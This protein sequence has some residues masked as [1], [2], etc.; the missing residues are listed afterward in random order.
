MQSWIK[1][2]R[3]PG[4][5]IHAFAE[6]CILP[7][8]FLNNSPDIHF[9]IRG[10]YTRSVDLLFILTEL[11][12][13]TWVSAEV[14]SYGTAFLLQS[15]DSPHVGFLKRYFYLKLQCL[16]LDG[17][18]NEIWYTQIYNWM[19]VYCYCGYLRIR[20]MNIDL[21]PHTLKKCFSTNFEV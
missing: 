3:D 10:Y 16:G 5:L 11:A 4:I 7:N 18:R 9:P 21:G 17:F 8:D 12:A 1:I 13:A 15:A 20:P 19:W 6:V 2:Q 14:Q